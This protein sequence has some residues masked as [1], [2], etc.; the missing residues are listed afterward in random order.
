MAILRPHSLVRIAICLLT[1]LMLFTLLWGDDALEERLVSNDAS[2]RDSAVADFDK[3]PSDARR[4]T[5]TTLLSY[6]SEC[7]AGSQR[8]RGRQSIICR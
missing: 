7:G 2:V 8:A 5:I 1:L 4:S 6:L 3:M